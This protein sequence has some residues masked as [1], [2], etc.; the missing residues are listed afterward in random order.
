MVFFTVFLCLWF[1]FFDF[2]FVV[3]C[4]GFFFGG[5]GWCFILFL[6]L[7]LQLLLVEEWNIVQLGSSDTQSLNWVLPTTILTLCCILYTDLLNF[8][9]NDWIFP[10]QHK[11]FAI[12]LS[13]PTEGRPVVHVHSRW[14]GCSRKASFF[15]AWL[16]EKKQH[17]CPVHPGHTEKEHLSRAAAWGTALMYVNSSE[18]SEILQVGGSSAWIWGKATAA[19][20]F[21]LLWC[22]GL[23]TVSENFM[24]LKAASSPHKLICLGFVWE[25]VCIILCCIC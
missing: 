16:Q 13:N 17:P 21:Y 14:G 7:F 18:N 3:V 5:G 20:L 6:L 12:L 9:T 11:F 15:P 24:P 23:L 25:G 10:E 19:K 1:L 4:V 2:D 22:C 8:I